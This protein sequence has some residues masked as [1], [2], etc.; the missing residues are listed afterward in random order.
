MKHVSLC[1]RQVHGVQDKQA[2]CIMVSTTGAASATSG[3]SLC[4]AEAEWSSLE[5]SSLLDLLP[6]CAPHL[7][8]VSTTT[9]RRGGGGGQNLGDCYATWQ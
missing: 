1:T 2:A 4:A 7:L 9:T 8:P 3:C 5:W 6:V